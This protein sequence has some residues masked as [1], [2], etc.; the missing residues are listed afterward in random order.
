[1][2]DRAELL[3]IGDVHLGTRPSRVPVDGSWG[4]DPDE[5][6]PAAALKLAVDLA[7]ERGVDA[8]LFAGDVVE[9]TNARFEAVPPLESAVHRLFDAGIQVVAVAGNHDVDALPRLASLLE[10][11]TLLGAGGEWESYAVTKD[12]EPVAEIIGWSFG[13]RRVMESPVAALLENPLPRIPGALPRIGLLHADLGASGGPYAPV[14]QV[15]LDET[16]YDAWLLGHIHK[17]SI[18][19]LAAPA[20]RPPAG[21]LGSLVGLDPS[22]AGPHGPWMVRIRGDGAVGLEH[23]PIAPLRWEHLSVSVDGLEHPDDVGDRLFRE[24]GEFVRRIG[25]EAPLPRALGLRAT[26]TG[27][28]PCHEGIRRAIASGDWKGRPRRVDGTVVFYDRIRAATMPRIELSEIAK[29]DDP[30]ALLARRLIRLRDGG[31]ASREL[32]ADAREA[33][34]STAG[35]EVWRRASDH[36]SH[37][38]PLS[39]AVLRDLLLRAGM[40]ALAA[41]LAELAGRSRA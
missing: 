3:A 37:V 36:R 2:A 41:M 6:T 27:P 33:L 30:P 5:L 25:R 11:F 21:Y 23:L 24:A 13:A 26:L 10:G 35:S 15:E 17:P 39:D 14:R 7:I 34:K 22:E 40:D 9:S 29:G 31:E 18:D 12:G 28:S 19:R 16:G 1:M 4:A 32:L 38:D 20:D 8:V